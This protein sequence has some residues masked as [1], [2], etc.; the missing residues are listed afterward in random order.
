MSRKLYRFDPD[1]GQVVQIEHGTL[2]AR[3]QCV[4][5]AQALQE[6][7]KRLPASYKPYA[8]HDWR[9]SRDSGRNGRGSMLEGG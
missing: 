2:S 5:P 8:P 9:D 6:V 4:R 3:S 7:G 1:L